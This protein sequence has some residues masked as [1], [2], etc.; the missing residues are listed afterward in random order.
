MPVQSEVF[1]RRDV[2]RGEVASIRSMRQPEQETDADD[3]V[4][5]VH[6]GHGEVERE[7]DLGALRHV[8]SE[9][10]LVHDAV[11]TRIDKLGDVKMRAG[12][13]VLLPLLV[14]LV[15]LDPKEE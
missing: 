3:H 2:P 11:C 13:V 15:V 5:G 8:R 10:L 1:Y 7:E 9:R 6:A 14:V 4:D 12:D